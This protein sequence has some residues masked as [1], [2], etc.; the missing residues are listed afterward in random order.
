MTVSDP[1][2]SVVIEAAQGRLGRYQF[3]TRTATSLVCAVCGTYVGALIEVDGKA[4]TVV[5][6][7]GLGLDVFTSRT[8]DPMVYDSETPE[9]RIDRRKAKWT[10]AEIRLRYYY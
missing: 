1:A 9:E 2:G 6:A 4:W 5:N 3:A 7:R 10:P 8:P